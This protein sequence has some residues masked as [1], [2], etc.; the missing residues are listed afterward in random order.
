M[1]MTQTFYSCTVTGGHTS[2]SSSILFPLKEACRA[3]FK[4]RKGLLGI[5]RPR[6]MVAN[7]LAI[8]RDP[9]VRRSLSPTAGIFI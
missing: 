7:P 1:L 2:I 9:G 4:M 3:H 6:I 8:R 5:L